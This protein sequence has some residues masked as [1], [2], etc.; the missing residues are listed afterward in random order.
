MTDKNIKSAKA[1]WI[2][3]PGEFEH[4]YVCEVN[5]RKYKRNNVTMPIWKVAPI[6]QYVRFVTTVHLE[7]EEEFIVKAD[8]IC[9]VETGRNRFV[10]KKDGKYLLR[11]GTHQL[12]VS[13]YAEPGKI[14]TFFSEGETIRSG[15]DWTCTL[16]DGKFIGADSGGFY[17]LDSSPNNYRLPLFRQNYADKKQMDGFT[18]YDF[19]KETFGYICIES[20]E[21]KGSLNIYY[22]ESV[23]EACDFEFCET[24]ETVALTE[25][26]VQTPLTRAF[27]Y[28]AIQEI[29]NGNYDD[30]YMLYEYSPQ[31]RCSKIDFQ[32][33]LLQKIW[34]T[35]LYTLQLNT[36]EFFL[37]GIKRDRWVWS[38]DATQAYLMNWYSFFDE[39]TAK[40][41]QIALS[42]KG[43]PT[44]HIN[45]IVDYTLYW[46]ISFYDHYKYTKDTA[47]LEMWYERFVEITE[48]VL[49]CTD[50]KYRLIKRPADWVFV[51]WGKGVTQ[52]YD[53]FS[54]L[55]ILLYGAMK[56]AKCVSEIAGFADRTIRYEDIAKKVYDDLQKNYYSKDHN[57]FIYGIKDNKRAELVLRQPN[58]M[59]ILLG[60]ADEE[61]CE[62]I[63]NNVILNPQIPVLETPYM[64]FYELS[65]LCQLGKEELVFNDILSYWGG[66]LGEGA[67]SFWELYRPWET[68]PE[69]FAMY[70]YKYGKSLCH[71]WGAAPIWIIGRYFIGLEPCGA[72]YEKFRLTPKVKCIGDFSAEFCIGKGSV[73]LVY[74]DNILSVWSGTHHGEI[75]VDGQTHII[76]KNKE[77]SIK[78]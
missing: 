16:Y 3:Y 55:Q 29:E 9:T 53:S 58:I 8:G 10:R 37:D 56:A 4:K 69:R 14:C 51:D 6:Y 60:V 18:L 26:L 35:S 2:W 5:M 64:R 22:G 34:D 42:G 38:G 32:N 7:K 40:R 78:I 24:L 41:T 68:G 45:G 75:V 15:K 23:E 20:K 48:Y 76:E 54:F 1:E 49:S 52:D 74:R 46:L 62:D 30:I 47:F 28:V 21:P 36:R 61:Q 66:M 70:N 25:K 72:G 73:K 12:S 13:V 39:Q 65:A 19:G 33:Q 44:Q 50:E 63:L 27:R 17:D 43:L 77:F 31:L 11:E 59:A 57:A 71:A 67:T